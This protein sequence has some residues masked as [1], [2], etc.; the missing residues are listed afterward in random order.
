MQLQIYTLARAL[1]YSN[2]SSY[3]YIFYTHTHVRPHK[4]NEL[5]LT[6]GK[7]VVK[8]KKATFAV[9]AVGVTK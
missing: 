6:F 9:V 2:L 1:V 3:T 5:S 4:N 8:K 7:Y